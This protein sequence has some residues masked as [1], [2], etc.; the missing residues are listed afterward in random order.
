MAELSMS[1]N[2]AGKNLIVSYAVWW[3]GYVLSQTLAL[4]YSF[5]FSLKLSLTDA[6]LTNTILGLAAYTMI[7]LIRF[8]QPRMIL[9]LIDSIG[10]AILSMFIMQWLAK[11]L[12][13]DNPDYL[14]FLQKSFI[15]RCFF[16]WIMISL[17]AASASLWF[18]IRDQQEM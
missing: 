8:Y 15:I 10:M 14:I 11:F 12:I 2:V 16:A 6:L 18:Y 3:L 13:T 17:F 1:K 7:N 9:R 4:Y 5:G